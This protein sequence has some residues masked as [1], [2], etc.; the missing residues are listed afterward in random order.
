MY[1]MLRTVRAQ[2]PQLR[3]AAAASLVSFR[4]VCFFL[5]LLNL[6]RELVAASAIFWKAS[7]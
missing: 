5:R 7:K 1:L 3:G 4:L 2:L 6:P